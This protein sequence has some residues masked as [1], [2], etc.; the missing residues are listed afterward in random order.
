MRQALRMINSESCLWGCCFMFGCHSWDILHIYCLNGQQRMRFCAGKTCAS[1]LRTCFHL[2]SLFLF[3]F[4][5]IRMFKHPVAICSWISDGEQDVSFCDGY[6][7]FWDDEIVGQ[8]DSG[9]PTIWSGEEFCG[10]AIDLHRFV[11]NVLAW[12]V[13]SVERRH[14]AS[15]TDPSFHAICNH[16]TNMILIDESFH[17][18]PCM[19][20]HSR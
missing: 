16:H 13:A 18:D 7:C 1:D 6:G 11:N 10:W 20:R 15:V 12:I 5:D 3:V 8:C 14:N 2:C 17:V 4:E 9:E 19:C